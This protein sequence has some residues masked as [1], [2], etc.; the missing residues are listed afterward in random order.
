M[1]DETPAPGVG[2][3][4]DPRVIYRWPSRTA[5][6]APARTLARVLQDL[7]RYVR[8]YVVLS[9]PQAVA[10]TIWVAHGH[11]FAVAEATPYL[12][13]TSAVKQSG[14]TRLLEVLEPIVPAPRFTGR[15]SAAVL[16]AE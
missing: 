9:D 11:A 14:K 3:G 5:P 10:C 4:G 2:R 1:T 13:V 15:A 12:N 6:P 16:T 8:R 7:T